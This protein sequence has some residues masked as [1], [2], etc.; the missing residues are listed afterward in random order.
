MST[1]DQ[2]PLKACLERRQNRSLLPASQELPSRSLF[3]VG[4]GMGTCSDSNAM[5]PEYS[6]CTLL[7]ELQDGTKRPADSFYEWMQQ[8]CIEQCAMLLAIKKQLLESRGDLEWLPDRMERQSERL[9]LAT[10]GCANFPI[11]VVFG[12]ASWWRGS[13]A[14]ILSEL[15]SLIN[16]RRQ[17]E[18]E[19]RT[20][21][22][23]IPKMQEEGLVSNTSISF[24]FFLTHVQKMLVP[25]LLSNFPCRKED[26]GTWLKKDALAGRD[27]YSSQLLNKKFPVTWRE[28]NE[29]TH[30]LFGEG[31]NEEGTI[32]KYAFTTDP[33]YSLNMPFSSRFTGNNDELL[34]FEVSGDISYT[35][36]G[37]GSYSGLGSYTCGEYGH[38][39]Y[40]VQAASESDESDDD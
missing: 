13:N 36:Y 30:E 31:V 14:S 17:S 4:V 20:L 27:P 3:F 37:S 26:F 8:R 18:L 10:E 23:A 28:G 34:N 25:D 32:E 9:N 19:Y 16:D 38:C 33:N 40:S 12:C 24:E 22:V 5:G 39:S 29:I 2:C 7:V 1:Q 15:E 11:N 21:I 6:K 35:S